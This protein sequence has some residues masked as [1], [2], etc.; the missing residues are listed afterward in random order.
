[1]ENPSDSWSCRVMSSSVK[2]ISGRAAPLPENQ[3][4]FTSSLQKLY[5]SGTIREGRKTSKLIR[6]FIIDNLKQKG[7]PVSDVQI[8]DRVDPP[9]PLLWASGRFFQVIPEEALFTH[10][11]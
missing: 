9:L 11:G 4:I 7:F 10:D 3:I 8:P 5:G 2:D 1:M 6:F